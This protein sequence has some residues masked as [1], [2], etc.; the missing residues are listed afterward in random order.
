MNHF[1]KGMYIDSIIFYC[2][3]GAYVFLLF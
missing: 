2:H 3:F 1:F